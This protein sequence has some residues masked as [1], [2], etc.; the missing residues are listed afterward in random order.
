VWENREEEERVTVEEERIREIW[1][2][3]MGNP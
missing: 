3:K 2:F 1:V